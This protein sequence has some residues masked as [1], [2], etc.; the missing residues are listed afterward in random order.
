MVWTN[1]SF[2]GDHVKIT[3]GE[4]DLDHEVSINKT[5][6]CLLLFCL[7]KHFEGQ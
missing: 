1:L 7:D 4:D 3:M 6:Y 5:V 2:N